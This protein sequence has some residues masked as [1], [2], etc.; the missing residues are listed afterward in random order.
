MNEVKTPRGTGQNI[1]LIGIMGC[2][3][4]TVGRMLAQTLSMDFIDM[5][6]EIEM[7]HGPISEMFAAF[8]EDYFRDI[9][10]G[11]ALELASRISTVISTGGGIVKRAVNLKALR[12]NGIVFFLDRPTS[13]IHKT[14]KTENRPLLA[15]NPEILDSLLKERYQLYVEQSDWKIDA[16]GSVKKTIELIID[17]WKNVVLSS[18]D[19]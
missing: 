14:L 4:S 19:S 12:C 13:E 5:D 3:K 9:E 8:G 18:D 17:L 10:S 7:R 11:L 6:V 2:G 1:I 16:S 15:K